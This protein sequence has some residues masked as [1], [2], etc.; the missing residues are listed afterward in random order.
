MRSRAPPSCGGRCASMCACSPTTWARSCLLNEARQIAQFI[1]GAEP[2]GGKPRSPP[3]TRCVPS[4]QGSFTGRYTTIQMN[5]AGHQRSRRPIGSQPGTRQDVAWC[6]ALLRGPRAASERLASITPRTRCVWRDC[7]W[8]RGIGTSWGPFS[9]GADDRLEPA[10]AP[11]LI[12]EPI[13]DP[14]RVRFEPGERLP[15]AHGS[16]STP[17]RFLSTTVSTSPGSVETVIRPSSAEHADAPDTRLG[18]Q[19]LDNDVIE[20]GAVIAQHLVMR[21]A[22]NQIGDPVGRLLHHG[23][24]KNAARNAG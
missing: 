6:C 4:D 19:L 2:A 12:G 22:H 23:P 14:G 17:R 20:C 21:A 1:V 13:R 5:I 8:H 10:M 9:I 24:E 7:T 15:I 16:H 3:A 18:A 11:C